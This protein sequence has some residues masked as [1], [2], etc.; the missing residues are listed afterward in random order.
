MAEEKKGDSKLEIAGIVLI[1]ALGVSMYHGHS[2]LRRDVIDIE[3]AVIAHT[4]VNGR[5]PTDI[6]I[7]YLEDEFA[8]STQDSK[9][10]E[11]EGSLPSVAYRWDGTSNYHW[12]GGAQIPGGT[13]TG[14]QL[15][16]KEERVDL[17]DTPDPGLLAKIIEVI[18]EEIAS[19]A[20]DGD[21][22][23][24]PSVLLFRV[25]GTA[26]LGAHN[27]IVVTHSQKPIGFGE[28][29][30]VAEPM[31]Y[32]P[33]TVPNS[34]TLVFTGY[35]RPGLASHITEI[36]QRWGIASE[37][38]AGR[39]LAL[40]G[41]WMTQEVK[42]PVVDLMLPVLPALFS[43]TLIALWQMLS[44][45]RRLRTGECVVGALAPLPSA[46]HVHGLSI[47][48]AQ[49]VEVAGWLVIPMSCLLL[50]GLFTGVVWSSIDP[51]EY[52]YLYVADLPKRALLLG[53]ACALVFTSMVPAVSIY[54]SLLERSRLAAAGATPS[55]DS[56]KD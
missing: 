12:A 26:G 6:W 41:K 4:L 30:T 32:F 46:R 13:T 37:S 34:P 16:T 48:L 23:T 24:T 43:L 35:S 47:R 20:E 18:E 25:E 9:A 28:R 8:E 54:L 51:Q 29:V 2:N 49:Y 14:W 21:G 45:S 19:E 39:Y 50:A 3:Q 36:A 31:V 22:G 27:I 11:W 33:D 7:T 53:I 44:L 56:E 55:E 10:L 38:V 40:K 52:Q 5:V 42:L 17:K 15:M 1:L